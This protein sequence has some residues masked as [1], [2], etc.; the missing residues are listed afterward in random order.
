MTTTSNSSRFGDSEGQQA[1]ATRNEP[2]DAVDDIVGHSHPFCT[3]LAYR[4]G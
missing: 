4:R 1:K 2:E 3:F